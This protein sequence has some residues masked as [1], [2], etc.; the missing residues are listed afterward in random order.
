VRAIKKLRCL[1]CRKRMGVQNTDLVLENF[2]TGK[3]THSEAQCN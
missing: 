3:L 1:S 2:A